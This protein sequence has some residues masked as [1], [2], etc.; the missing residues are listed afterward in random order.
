MTEKITPELRDDTARVEAFSDGVFAII[1][2]LLILEI[3]VPH[4][5]RAGGLANAVVHL[6][7]SF[8]AFAA[9]FFTIGVMWMNHHRVYTLIGKS[10]QRMMALNLV[11]LFTISI[12]PFPT[13]LI[14]QYIH[15]RDG[16]IGALCY[17]LTFVATALAY[18]VFWRYVSKDHRLIADGT[19][20]EDVAAISKQYRWGPVM[21]IVFVAASFNTTLTL[22]LHLGAA[23]FFALPPSRF[24]R[25]APSRGR[26]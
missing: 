26:V 6:W 20:P 25:N 15:H 11:L 19:D 18:N 5:I 14:A 24:A 2:T 23:I 9:S 3:R 16:W 8:L 13:G 7:P 1:I 17:N 22:I 21:Y 12:I 4:D 10:D